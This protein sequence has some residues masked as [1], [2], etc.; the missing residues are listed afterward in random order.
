MAINL[1]IICGGIYVVL[2]VIAAIGDFRKLTIPNWISV[3]LVGL[4]FAYAG[5]VQPDLPILNHVLVGVAALV[6]GLPLFGLR[7]MAGGDIKL[8]SAVALW[9]GPAHI[10]KILFIVTF[11]GALLGIAILVMR[12]VHQAYGASGLP[13]KL[14]KLMPAWARHGLCPYGLPIS[15]GALFLVPDIFLR[16]P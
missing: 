6:I 9:A 8:F 13:P 3:A 4:F 7:V 5:L 15:A 14:D 12:K 11:L 2:L 1:S 16:G 10:V